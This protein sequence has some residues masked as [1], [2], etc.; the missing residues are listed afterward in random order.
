MVMLVVLVVVAVAATAPARVHARTAGE[1]GVA[2]AEKP[3]APPWNFPGEAQ[4]ARRRVGDGPGAAISTRHRQCGHCDATASAAAAAA[5]AA[6]IVAIIILFCCWG[7]TRSTVTL[8]SSRKRRP[9]E[10]T[11]SSRHGACEEGCG[12]YRTYCSTRSHHASHHAPAAQGPPRGTTTMTT[13]VQSPVQSLVRGRPAQ[14]VMNVPSN[15]AEAAV[16]VALLFFV[17]CSSP[18]SP[19]PSPPT[20]PPPPPP[21]LSLFLPASAAK[22]LLAAADRGSQAGLSCTRGSTEPPPR[23]RQQPKQEVPPVASPRPAYCRSS[24]S[25]WSSSSS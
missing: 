2:E 13:T 25:L 11:H 23:L 19:S 15:N 14:S 1:D 12:W 18:S 4:Q 22:I 10:G 16:L 5:A 6:A 24:P 9:P 21:R 17:F 7:A 8:R 20:L 3:P